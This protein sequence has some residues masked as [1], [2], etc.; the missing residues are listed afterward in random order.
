MDKLQIVRIPVY[1]LSNPLLLGNEK[2]VEKMHT[3]HKLH[4]CQERKE[5]SIQISSS[6]HVQCTAFD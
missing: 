2:L 3:R 4:N 5:Q 1:V 6:F